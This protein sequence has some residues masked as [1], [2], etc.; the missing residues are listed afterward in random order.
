MAHTGAELARKR[1]RHISAP[2]I[3]LRAVGERCR[4][5]GTGEVEVDVASV[6]HADVPA[7][8]GGSPLDSDFVSRGDKLR[9]PAESRV[10]AGHRV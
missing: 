10:R 9:E 3:H 1:R 7:L 5:E 6:S 2:C 4:R 8:F